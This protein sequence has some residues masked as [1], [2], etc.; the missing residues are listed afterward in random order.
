LTLRKLTFK[1]LTL[2][3]VSLEGAYPKGDNLIVAHYLTFDQFSKMKNLR[4]QN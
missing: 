4:I 3:K 1:K 2:E